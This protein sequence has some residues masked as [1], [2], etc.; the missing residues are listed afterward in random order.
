MYYYLCS[1]SLLSHCCTSLLRRCPYRRGVL[2][3]RCSCTR[4]GQDWAT[5]RICRSHGRISPAPDDLQVAVRESFSPHRIAPTIDASMWRHD[6]S[7]VTQQIHVSVTYTNMWR[8]QENARAN[9]ILFRRENCLFFKKILVICPLKQANQR[10]GHTAI[11]IHIR[12]RLHR[13][14]PFSK[15]R[16]YPSLRRKIHITLRGQSPTI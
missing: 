15:P 16:N 7:G 13:V 8:K 12:N 4:Q 11:W 6:H 1:S 14:Q 3:S 10:S 2:R 5:C 9:Y